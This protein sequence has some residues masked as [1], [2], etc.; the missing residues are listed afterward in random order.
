MASFRQLP[1]GKW[2]AIVRKRGQAPQYR[3][4][5]FK[6]D[7][8]DWSA[9]VE[10]KIN[11]R[12][13]SDLASAREKTLGDALD[14]YAEYVKSRHRGANIELFRIDRWK[15]HQLSKRCIAD[16]T[17]EDIELFRKA[18]QAEGVKDGTIRNDINVLRAA[19]K[20]G[21]F[22]VECPVARSFRVLK[23]ADER[24]RRLSELEERYLF[25]ALS[26]TQ[27]SRPDKANRW[28][29]LV[30]RFAIE[31]S[32]RLG[33]VMSL[34]WERVDMKAAVAT[35]LKE[36]T[37]NGEARLVPLSPGALDTLKSARALNPALTGP[38]FQTTRSAFD[39]GWK[40]A[41]ARARKAYENDCRASSLP[42]DLGFLDDFRFHD[43]RHEAASR[44]ALQ[45]SHFDLKQIT[46]HKDDRS[47]ARYVNKSR[48]DVS[49]IARKMKTR[50]S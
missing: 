10:T 4:F 46:G 21:D 29:S 2:Q 45:F 1:S 34:R 39:Q 41:K 12:V 36:D 22:K 9:D 17:S 5:D 49:E 50:V 8:Q 3:S 47:L 31:T 23:P 13:F 6:Q 37:K 28:L 35:L 7:A 18:R 43:F 25:A 19:W 15:S 48:E 26:S 38:V 27:C 33:E 11:R 30:A 14:E 44:W 32:A 40:R 16:I 20:H 42:V 24:D